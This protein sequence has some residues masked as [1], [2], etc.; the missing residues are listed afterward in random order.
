MRRQTKKNKQINPEEINPTSTDITLILESTDI[1]KHKTV[2][3]INI[4]N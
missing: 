3:K 2:G 1:T 4:K